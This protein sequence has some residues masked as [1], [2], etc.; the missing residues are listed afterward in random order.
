[1]RKRG[2]AK[3]KILTEC[4]LCGRKT[5][6]LYWVAPVSGARSEDPYCA[7]CYEEEF[8]RAARESLDWSAEDILR[9]KAIKRF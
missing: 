9:R 8:R 5:D 3:K 2:N 6:N 4:V 1:M 7:R